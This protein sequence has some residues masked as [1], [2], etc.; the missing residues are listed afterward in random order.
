[1]ATRRKLRNPP[2]GRSAAIFVGEMVA[3]SLAAF[4]GLV[5]GG[6]G[7][8]GVADGFPAGSGVLVS[9]IQACAPDPEGVWS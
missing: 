1:M 8:Q 2:F 6:V 9:L 3:S 5:G 4:A 7:E